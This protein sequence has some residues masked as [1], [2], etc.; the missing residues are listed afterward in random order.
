MGPEWHAVASASLKGSL[1]GATLVSAFFSISIALPS[2]YRDFDIAALLTF[3]PFIFIFAFIP[4]IIGTYLCLMLFGMP[5][6]SLSQARL[7]SLFGLGI[8]IT[9]ALIIST[10]LAGL[11]SSPHFVLVLIAYALPAAIYYRREILLERA[12]S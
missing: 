2:P 11:I 9:G 10:I 3:A 8:A 7:D 1:V 4:G 12:I 5:L 6:A